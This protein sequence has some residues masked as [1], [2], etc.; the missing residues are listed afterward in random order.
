MLLDEL[1]SE[2]DKRGCDLRLHR[3]YGVFSAELD[4]DDGL[5][6]IG[7]NLNSALQGLQR[8]LDKFAGRPHSVCRTGLRAIRG[9]LRRV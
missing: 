6:G 9:G 2:A 8:E 1:L 7:G 3:Q 4:D 5:R